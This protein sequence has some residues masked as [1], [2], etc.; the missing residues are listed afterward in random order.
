[1]SCILLILSLI[2]IDSDCVSLRL[3]QSSY[4]GKPYGYGAFDGC[5]GLTSLI[6]PRNVN[7]IEPYAFNGTTNLKTITINAET[8]P[9]ISYISIKSSFE[10]IYV[11]AESLSAYQTDDDWAYFKSKIKAIQN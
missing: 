8:P 5:S 6:I 9:S 1:M 2:Y 11:P 3:H 7:S 10:T 4:R